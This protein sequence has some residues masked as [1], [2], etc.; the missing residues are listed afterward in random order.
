M[1][2]LPIELL[3]STQM[4]LRLAIVAAP[5]SASLWI[6]PAAKLLFVIGSMEQHQQSPFSSVGEMYVFQIALRTVAGIRSFGF[7]RFGVS[8][9][10]VPLLSAIARFLFLSLCLFFPHLLFCC[11]S[12]TSVETGQ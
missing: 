7:P 6:C 12:V 11:S 10:G 9:I 3:Q 2:L 4:G 5:P 1:F 8:L